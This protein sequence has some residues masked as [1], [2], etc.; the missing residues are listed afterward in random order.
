MGAG[1]VLPRV[2]RNR[3]IPTRNS[4]SNLILAGG[5]APHC[6]RTNSVM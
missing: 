4:C 3:R 1:N 6:L 5:K 2:V